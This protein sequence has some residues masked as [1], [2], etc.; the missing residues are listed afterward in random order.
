ML[1]SKDPHVHSNLK[2]VTSEKCKDIVNSRE[3]ERDIVCK[4]SLC[5]KLCQL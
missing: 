3:R 4:L 5:Q 1:I 2:L